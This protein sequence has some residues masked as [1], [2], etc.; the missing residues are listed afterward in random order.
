MTEY[1]AFK[2][3]LDFFDHFEHAKKESRLNEW[4]YVSLSEFQ[5]AVTNLPTFLVYADQKGVDVN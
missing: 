5:V 3:N 1:P 4:Q 2:F